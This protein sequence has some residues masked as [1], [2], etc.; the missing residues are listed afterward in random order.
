MKN[1]FE[2]IPGLTS[3]NVIKEKLTLTEYP[4]ANLY[5]VSGSCTIYIASFL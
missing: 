3:L 5:C 1:T 4:W 2:K